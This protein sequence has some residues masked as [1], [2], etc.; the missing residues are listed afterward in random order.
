[1]YVSPNYDLY[2]FYR[3]TMRE[4]Y[5]YKKATEESLWHELW[6]IFVR[7]ITRPFRRD[8][9]RFLKVAEWF[10]LMYES[11]RGRAKIIF[12][13]RYKIGNPETWTL[14]I[15]DKILRDLPPEQRDFIIQR[16]FLVAQNN[17]VTREE[18]EANPILR[19]WIQRYILYYSKY[20]CSHNVYAFKLTPMTLYY[21]KG[22]A[23][24]YY[25][26]RYAFARDIK[27]D[28]YI[29]VSRPLDFHIFSMTYKYD[30]EYVNVL[31]YAGKGA[32]NM[33]DSVVSARDD[34]QLPMRKHPLRRLVF[35]PH[36]I[37]RDASKAL[38]RPEMVTNID[39]SCVYA[40]IGR[41]SSD[42]E[43]MDLE[44]PTR[45]IMY[46]KRRRFEELVSTLGWRR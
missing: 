21:G 36:H 24:R 23:V 28:P 2:I 17:P 11:I 4:N 25:V 40:I 15:H 19:Y 20:P 3:T 16:L 14:Y 8:Y 22:Y 34:K 30:W 31:G 29:G 7:S 39:H 10:R 9:E 27:A 6:E 13:V 46:G 43:L 32:C 38:G 44:V 33:D 42:N 41:G 35:Q 1:M 37:L 26:M 45:L 18:I 12:E 5:E